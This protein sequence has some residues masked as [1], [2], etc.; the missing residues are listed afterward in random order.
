M[1]YLS[2]IAGE[3][4][5][6]NPKCTHDLL[7]AFTITINDE[8]TNEERPLLVPLL[9]RLLGANVGSHD[10]YHEVTIA[11]RAYNSNNMYDQYLWSAEEKVA[12]LSG[13]ID[14]YDVAAGRTE[15]PVISPGRAHEAMA[16]IYAL[17][18]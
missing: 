4:W 9:C 12:W 3:E 11:L 18:E 7:R 16:A 10:P 5:S 17:A 15:T 6:D 2:V 13:L 14:T 1:E 8:L